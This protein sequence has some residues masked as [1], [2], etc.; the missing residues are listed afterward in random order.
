MLGCVRTAAR[1]A[2]PALRVVE[3][4]DRLGPRLQVARVACAPEV[5]GGEVT[6]RE[7]DHR[8]AEDLDAAPKLVNDREPAHGT[9]V[10]V[11]LRE[12]VRHVLRGHGRTPAPE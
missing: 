11:L 5:V 4:K 2:E 9:M 10:A 7:A 3:R 1:R 6:R 8:P 12:D